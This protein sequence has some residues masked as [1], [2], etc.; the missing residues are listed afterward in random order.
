MTQNSEA[1]DGTVSKGEG[2]LHRLFGKGAHEA[3]HPEAKAKL[4]AA[5]PLNLEDIQVSSCAATACRWCG[6]SCCKWAFPPRRA[7]C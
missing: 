5:G 7:N 4:G 3:A 1:T 6:I 2:F